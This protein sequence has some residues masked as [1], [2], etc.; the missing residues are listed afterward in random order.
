MVRA[1]GKDGSNGKDG[2]DG[3]DGKD[4]KDGIDG[5]DGVAVAPQ[6][7]INPSTYYWEVS[8]DGGGTWIGTNYYS[9]G[10]DG[11]DGKDAEAPEITAKQGTDGNYYWAINGTFIVTPDGKMVRAN[12]QDGKDGKDGVNG[13]NGQDGRAVSPQ[14]RIN[15]SNYIWEISYDG[16]N[17]WIS[18]NQTAKGNDG[19]NGQN[20]R[21]GIDG[22]NGADGDVVI[23][24]VQFITIDKTDVA[25]FYLAT[26]YFDVPIMSN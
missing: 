6:I 21:N 5:K 13:K 9:K 15:P 8:Y 12:G 4:G 11:A 3:I 14:L 10:K 18:T 17:T 19:A 25:R 26:G 24:S 16:G 20:G 22:R 7:R 23:K 1:S 2:K